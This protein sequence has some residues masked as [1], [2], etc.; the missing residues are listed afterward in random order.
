MQVAT[1]HTLSTKLALLLGLTAKSAAL[2]GTFEER[3]DKPNFCALASGAPQLT[4]I[5]ISM[6]DSV[7]NDHLTQPNVIIAESLS[8]YG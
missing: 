1:P 6:T 3:E 2:E 5:S 8:T 7:M 4:F